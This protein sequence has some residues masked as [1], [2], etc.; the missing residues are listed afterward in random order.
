MAGRIQLT[1]RGVQDIYFTENPDYSYFVQLFRKHT[2]YTTQFVKLDIDNDAEFGKTVSVTIPK[3]QGDMIKTIS[4]EIELDKI[5]GADVT[6]IGYVES[7]GHALIEYIDMYIGDE[8]IQHIPSD[9]LQIYSE[10]NYTQSKQK[11]LEKLIGKY[12]DRTSDV[13]VSSGVILGHLGPAT[14][15][16]KLFIDI[17]F[18]FYRKPELAVPLCAMCFQE[19]RLEIKFRDLK[20]CLVKTDPPIDKTLQTTTLDFDLISS[21]TLTSNVLVASSDGSN[22]ATNVNSTVVIPGKT[23]FNGVGVVSPAMNIIVTSEIIYRY[24]NDQ[25]VAYTA[26]IDPANTIKYSD[27]GNVIVEV[28][29][30]IWVWN[31]TEYI[32]TSNPNIVALSRD[33]NFYCV[34]GTPLPRLEVFNTATGTR[35]GGAVDKA[36]VFPVSQVHLSFDGTKLIVV[37]NNDILYVYQYTTDWFRYGQDVTLFDEL[38]LTTFARDGNSFFIYNPSEQHNHDNN[39]GFDTGVGRLYVYDIIS[40]QWIEVHRYKGSNGTYASMSDDKLKLHIKKSDTE[41]DVITLK[42]LTR[43]VEGYDEVVI[44][45]VENIVDAGS[46]VYG[47]GYQSLVSQIQPIIAFNA[48][49]SYSE[50]GQQFLPVGPLTDVV[51]SDNGLVHVDYYSTGAQVRVFKRNSII[52]GFQQLFITNVNNNIIANQNQISVTASNNQFS[53]F[54]ISKTGRYFAI[55]DHVNGQVLIYEVLNS[56]FRNIQYVEGNPPTPNIL[57]NT[58]F[59]SSLSGLIFSDD[60]TSFTLYGSNDVKTYLISDPTTVTQTISENVFPHPIAA[61]SR[62]LNRFIKHDSS[63]N[64]IK[65]FTINSNGTTISSLPINLQGTPITFDFSKDGTLMAVVTSTFTYIYSYDGSG[66]RQKSSLFVGLDTFVK[67][68]MLDD[69]NTLFYVKSELPANRTLID[70]YKYENNTWIRIHQENDNTTINSEGMGHVSRNGQHIIS[71]V[72]GNT[73]FPKRNIR[74]KNINTQD[75]TVVVGVDKDISQVYPKQIRSCK[76]S[77]E[78]IFLDKYERAI[79][80]NM[81]KDYVITQ[82]QHNRFLAPKAIQSHKFRTT[83]LNPVKEL[84]FVIRRENNQEYLDFVSPFDYDNDKITSE[85]KLIFYEN[86][87]SLEFK[88]NDTQVLDQDTG[89]FAFL[90]AIQ[91][92]IHHSKT[93]L[94]RRFYTYSFA[95][96]PEQHFPTGQVNFSLVNNQLFTFNLTQNTTSDR[97]VDIY[98]LSYNILRLDKGMMRVMFNTT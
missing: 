40:T 19:I 44:Q 39:S 7:I 16:K 73:A 33:G 26:S 83:F 90:K 47:A 56:S 14:E 20:N 70:L 96:E 27:D 38:G 69:G 30:G 57:A 58:S 34:D 1:T 68:H 49:T 92:A 37:L 77:L 43:S 4:L 17:P 18:Y 10:Q 53:K 64:I 65:I 71:L 46:N 23:V 32:F 35:L 63:N 80:K 54:N 97:H 9:Y 66:W 62:D 84:F 12:P 22:V 86:L 74:L 48:N 95:C 50:N 31:G 55:E 91:P 36:A 78:V 88:L 45:S 85:N 98:A 60:E 24:E 81:R 76:L 75:L 72:T 61:L 79:V 52:D 6:R 15:T 29:N 5:A 82:L 87:K 2:N 42:E 94:I 28:G 25:W 11:A 3:D 21:D 89:N 93:P 41:T 8:K 51:V 13:P 67:F 59:G